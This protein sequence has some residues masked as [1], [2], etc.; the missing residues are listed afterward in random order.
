MSIED[1]ALRETARIRARNGPETVVGQPNGKTNGR[2]GPGNRAA[3]G[4]GRPVGVIT[5]TPAKIRAVLGREMLE[6]LA[7][8]DETLKNAFERWA[9]LLM[10][11]DERIRLAAET[12]LHEVTNGRAATTLQLAGPGGGTGELI[13]R[14]QEARPGG[15]APALPAVPEAP[16]LEAEVVKTEEVK[17]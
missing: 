10:S 6:A 14:W 17:S 5:A 3:I 16:S 2:F 15:E 13:L 7:R 8:G 4:H 9:S 12:F 11:P 1:E